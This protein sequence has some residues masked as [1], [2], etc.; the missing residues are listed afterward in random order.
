MAR[1]P[2]EGRRRRSGASS[3]RSGAPRQ[4]WRQARKA[5]A[6]VS[7]GERG[8][9]RVRV[10]GEAPGHEGLRGAGHGE[11]SG[12]IRRGPGFGSRRLVA[13]QMRSAE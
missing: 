12:R 4:G 5:G 9:P 2:R 8:L 1:P 10:S 7:A 11:S 13:G 6:T 3:L